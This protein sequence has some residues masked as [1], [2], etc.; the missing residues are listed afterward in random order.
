MAFDPIETRI[1]TAIPR[2]MVLMYQHDD[3][4]ANGG[5]Q[6]IE[7]DVIV[8]DQNGD[9]IKFNKSRGDL[10]PH[11]TTQQLTALR[12]FMDSMMQKAQNEFL[13]T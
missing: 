8:T 13:G 4:L 5:T 6:A 3:I 9:V 1:P 12:D 10:A 7:Y 2:L 11:L